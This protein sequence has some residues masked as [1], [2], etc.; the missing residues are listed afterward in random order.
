M[1]ERSVFAPTPFAR[2]L[3]LFLGAVFVG[4]A[5]GIG[6]QR[7]LLHLV[8]PQMA[9]NMSLALATTSTGAAH[10]RLVHRIFINPTI[11]SGAPPDPPGL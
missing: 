10:G 11:A 8:A 2:D 3:V 1:I 5:A 6:S 9:A 4:T 7:L